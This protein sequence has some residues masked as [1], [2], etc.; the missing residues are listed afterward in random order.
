[1]NREKKTKAVTMMA[2]FARIHMDIGASPTTTRG[3]EMIF[4]I[5]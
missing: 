3:N 1:M 2:A 4:F 5:G